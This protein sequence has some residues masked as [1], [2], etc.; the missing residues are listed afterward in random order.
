[1][2][3]MNNLETTSQRKLLIKSGRETNNFSKQ[4][5]EM[6]QYLS[7]EDGFNISLL[8][9]KTG[10]GHFEEFKHHKSSFIY[11]VE[12]GKGSFYLSGKEHKVK[13]GDV[14]A[15]PPGTGIYYLGNMKMKLIC[16]PAWEEEFEEHIRDIES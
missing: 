16:Q 8:E 13:A 11:I 3:S 6:R 12:K 4:G 5:V 1:M 15:I 2:E 9:L 7:Q 14:V 10:K